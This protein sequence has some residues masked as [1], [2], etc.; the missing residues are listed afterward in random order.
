MSK[1]DSRV[2]TEIQAYHTALK[3]ASETQGLTALTYLWQAFEYYLE[4]E[5][6][7]LAIRLLSPWPGLQQSLQRLGNCLYPELIGPSAH[8][9]DNR[10]SQHALPDTLK[11]WINWLLPA[12]RPRLSVCMIV[13][14]EVQNLSACLQSV[15]SLAD[16][17]IIVDTGSTDGT[18]ALALAH[19]KVRLT[20]IPWP[21]DFS[22]ARNTSLAQASGDWIMI[23]D[24]DERLLPQSLGML[25]IL[26]GHP[27]LGWQVYLSQVQHLLPDNQFYTWATRLFRRDPALR[28]TGALHELPVKWTQPAWLLQVSVPFL[29][30]HRG[31]L[32][33]VY[34]SRQ[35]S[36]RVTHLEDLISK[37]ETVTPY[38]LYH[39]AYLLVNG[40]DVTS[41]PATAERLLWQALEQSQPWQGK[42]PPRPEFLLASTPAVVIL[43]AQ[44]YA[45]H[46]R[47]ESLARLYAR[48]ETE[49]PL[50]PFPALA[51]A[52]LRALGRYDEARI[53]WLRC[54]DPGL[55]PIKQHEGW[56]TQALEGLL[57]IGL[58]QHD[59]FLALW[60]VRRLRERFPSG[61]L[62][63]R[64]YDLVRLHRQLEDLL[65]LPPGT[66]IDRL[67]F[68]IKRS[69]Q[70]QD[71]ESLA[72]YTF[73][74]LCEAWDLT[75]LQDALKALSQLQA[76]AL[77]AAV[78]GLG[79]SVYPQAQVFK[80][81]MV[82]E[83]G[84]S[85]WRLDPRQCSLPGGAYWLHL[86]RQP[87]ARP[88]VS[89]CMIVR[90]AA[91]TL[92][93]T[94][95]STEMLVDE[96]VIADT[97]SEDDTQN[98]IAAWAQ[99]HAVKSFELP[100]RD[101]F[102]WARNQ[103]LEQASGDWVF[104]ID[105]DE[106]LCPESVPL[107]KQIFSHPPSGL[108]VFALR[109]LNIYPDVQLNH[110]DWVPRIFARTPLIRYWGAIHNMQG[111]AYDAE[112]L[113]II[114]LTGVKIAHTGYTP[115]NVKRHRKADRLPVLAGLLTIQGLPNPYYLYHFAYALMYQYHPPDY[116]RALAL[117]DQSVSESERFQYR[118]PVPGWFPA[119]SRKVQILISRIL[120]HLGQDQELLQRYSAWNARIDEPEY[121]Y[122]YA[123]AALRQKLMP[124][125]RKGFSR[126]LQL[127][128][129][130]MP[131]AGYGSWR[132]WLGLTD[133]ALNTADWALGIEA[134][135]ALLAEPGPLQAQRLF[136]EW[137]QRMLYPANKPASRPDKLS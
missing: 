117:F 85:P 129:S 38:L 116:T 52:S 118:P 66:W 120:N 8:H 111:H 93:H 131:E 60:A 74:Y 125:A 137:W 102:S 49:C 89:L 135:Q 103:V 35:K 56:Q 64:T 41:D 78:A 75:V 98:V 97:G 84:T 67:E 77:A 55:I 26:L 57:N 10:F 73:A 109:C 65:D 76:P 99:N 20:E 6:L 96:L 100:W 18:Q 69:L 16:E 23:L 36:R 9:P 127:A 68:E 40:I 81:F 124:E 27:P 121:H 130:D 86:A 105:G 19:P 123:T 17:I 47:H 5:P 54:F 29:L 110:E 115:Q 92:L 134:F 133:V 30:E 24:A 50:T 94:L 79:R 12:A 72:F 91:D 87:A 33:E 7:S 90:N 28:F 112:R 48:F 80:S 122:W 62:P 22:I 2:P 113:V 104:A 11:P 132:A 31:N 34:Q 82:P 25:S 107:L 70:R 53:A 39:Y 101:D 108:Q 83:P 14:N 43:L 46:Q 15:D 51:A 44:L 106:V 119:P 4:P 136:S 128:V 45:Q 13:R 95:Q 1:A 42:I 88:R 71:P 63:E 59:G 3:S 126:C 21:E 61:Q 58:K 114:P 32:P 37:P